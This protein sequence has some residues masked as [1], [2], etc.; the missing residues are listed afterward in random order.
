VRPLPLLNDEVGRCIPG[1][2]TL[3]DGKVFAAELEGSILPELGD[4]IKGLPFFL[5]T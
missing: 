4:S 5:G 2:M 1:G 3:P